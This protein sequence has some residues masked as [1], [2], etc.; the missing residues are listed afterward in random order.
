MALLWNDLYIKNT[1]TSHKNPSPTILRDFTP[2]R[3]TKLPSLFTTQGTVLDGSMTIEAA[4]LLPILISVVLIMGGMIEAIR[5]HGKVQ[6][7]LWNIGTRMCVYG[8]LSEELSSRFTEEVE[9]VI[10]SLGKD[11]L[12]VLEL[13]YPVGPFGGAVSIPRFWMQNRFFGHMWTGY[14]ILDETPDL[15]VVYMTEYGNVYHTKRD[16]NYIDINAIR[17][18]SAQLAQKTNVEGNPYRACKK[19]E[20]AKL[21]DFYYITNAGDCYHWRADCPSIERLVFSM[22][23][24]E[25]RGVRPCSKCAGEG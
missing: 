8:Y 16:C 9:F 14:D 4:V 1:L 2:C 3:F 5:I 17:V 13:V 15:V 25:V 20:E 19:C 11:D 6:T 10:S 22:S 23:L 21:K 12:I 7:D 24:E 18:D